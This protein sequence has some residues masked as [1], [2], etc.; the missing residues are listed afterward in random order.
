MAPRAVSAPM[1]IGDGINPTW[2]AD[3][4]LHDSRTSL[5]FSYTPEGNKKGLRYHRLGDKE[6]APR[7]KEHKPDKEAIAQTV[8]KTLA[9]AVSGNLPPVGAK[10]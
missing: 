7:Q 3:G 9:Q 5:E 1:V 6:A 8:K 4:K 2:G 10:A